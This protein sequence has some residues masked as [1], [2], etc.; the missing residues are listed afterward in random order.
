MG[1][2]LITMTLETDA[3]FGAGESK[4]GLVNTEV[5]LDENNFPYLLSKTFLGVLRE[6]VEN[7]V[8]PTVNKGDSITDKR[9]KILKS[10]FLDI[11]SSNEKDELFNIKLSN[12]TIDKT[13]VNKLRDEKIKEYILGGNSKETPRK[14]EEHI[15]YKNSKEIATKAKL[16]SF[17][18]IEQATRINSN[19]VAE[20]G[21]LRAIRVINKGLVFTSILEINGNIEADDIKFIEKCL[22][23]VK[24]IG[25]GKTRGM[26]K[27]K[28]ELKDIADL[29]TEISKLDMPKNK[30]FIRYEFELKEPVKVSKSEEQ[31][32]FEPT[33]KHI[34][35]GTMRG[36]FFAQWLKNNNS[37]ALK[38]IKNI[39]YY[40]AYPVYVE[41]DNKY[42]TIPMPNIYRNDKQIA[43]NFCDKKHA[44]EYKFSRALDEKEDFIFE[45]IFDS[46]ESNS[47][48]SRPESQNCMY[49]FKPMPFCFAKKDK[50]GDDAIFTYDVDTKQYFHHTNKKENENIYRYEAIKP[51]YL[52]YGFLD[53]SKFENDKDREEVINLLIKN[54]DLWIGGS[55][56][57]GY[58]RVELKEILGY[59]SLEK[60]FANMGIIEDLNNEKNKDMLYLYSDYA[61]DLSEF[62]IDKKD[63]SLSLNKV[64]GYNNHWNARTPIREI[65][66]KGSVIRSIKEETE[67]LKNKLENK[68]VLTEEGL[69][70]VIQNP[71]VISLDKIYIFK[72]NKETQ[73]NYH[74]SDE[75]ST[76][77]KPFFEKFVESYIQRKIKSWITPYIESGEFQKFVKNIKSNLGTNFKTSANELINIIDNQKIWK[78]NLEESLKSWLSE[79]ESISLNREQIEN[80]HKFLDLEIIGNFTLERFIDDFSARVMYKASVFSEKNGIKSGKGLNINNPEIRSFNEQY[81]ELNQEVKRICGSLGLFQNTIKEAEV[82]IDL[83]RHILYYAVFSY[84]QDNK[85]KGG[86]TNV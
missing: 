3:C 85:N 58:G 79:K 69:G 15:A 21:S 28:L 77:Y 40:N 19:Q 17:M 68:S 48:Y 31:Y 67:G 22:K 9:L 43:K 16:E 47:I 57:T 49:K 30:K 64:T 20:D 41:A 25:I 6:N 14:L 63:M 27:V 53:L 8:M 86:Q 24:H 62:K 12:F 80:N 50:Y 54:T 60:A 82:Q 38:Y 26:G 61:G 83:L 51:G 71:K 84:D 81:K 59:E 32:D 37:N 52:Y 72:D 73:L 7:F 13:I 2:Y 39:N 70:V 35:G 23:T 1:K 34:P 11:K 78:N 66:E 33:H 29:E 44:W 46:Y 74:Y 56:K 75:T 76:N 18:K 42:Y 65:V 45:T 5:L 36:A 4:N 10:F 55:K